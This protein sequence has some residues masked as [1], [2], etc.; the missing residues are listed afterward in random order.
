MKNNVKKLRLENKI[1]E[2]IGG[3]ISKSQQSVSRLE[4]EQRDIDIYELCF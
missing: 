1:N 4:N 3:L 2:D